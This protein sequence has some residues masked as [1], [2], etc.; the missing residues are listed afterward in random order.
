MYERVL[1]AG[2]GK[3]V[4]TVRKESEHLCQV[5]GTLIR[6]NPTDYDIPPYLLE[7][8]RK[9][10]L[11]I[12]LGTIDALNR[13]LTLLEGPA[14]AGAKPESLAQVERDT[15]ETRDSHSSGPTATTPIE[16]IPGSGHTCLK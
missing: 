14:A 10:F 11:S 16:I 13:L 8:D 3:G 5:R 7:R 9:R 6:I 4:P 12:P 2:A 1:N 15:R